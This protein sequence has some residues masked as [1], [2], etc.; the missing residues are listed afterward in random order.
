VPFE[1]VPGITASNACAAYA[2]IPLTHRGLAKSVRVITG[3]RRNNQAL[4]FN[5]RDLADTETTLVVYMGL[6]NLDLICEELIGGG[7]PPDTPAAAIHK[8]STPD[9]KTVVGTLTTLPD[10]V[11]E[12]GLTAPTLVIVGAVVSLRETLAWYGPDVDRAG[13]TAKRA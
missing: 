9:Q 13:A 3:H 10:R 4:D 12:A 8:G 5:W 6:A 7:A 2:G 11:A 1:I